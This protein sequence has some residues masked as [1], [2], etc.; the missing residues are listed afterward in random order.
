MNDKTETKET[1][2]T[3]GSIAVDRSALVALV[4]L[5]KVAAALGMEDATKCMDD[6]M[7]KLAA[8]AAG[9]FATIV[10]AAYGIDDD[11]AAMHAAASARIIEMAEK[12]AEGGVE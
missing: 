9:S 11:D 12:D 10:Q 8:R 7:A 1:K 4:G 3:G 5:A 2:G 6:R